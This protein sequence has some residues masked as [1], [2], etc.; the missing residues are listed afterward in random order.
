MEQ[1]SRGN[2]DGPPL[3]ALLDANVLYSKVLSDYFVHAQFGRLIAV[4]W[5]SAILEEMIRN[6]KDKASKQFSD[7]EELRPRLDAA[8]GLRN[9]IRREYPRAIVEPGP[10]HFVPFAHLSVPDPDDRHVVAAAVAARA[11]YLCT[12]NTPDFPDPVMDHLGIQRVTPDQLLHGLA[13]DKPVEMLRAHQRTIAWT[14]G[15]THRKTLDT[16]RRAQAPNT[17]DRIEK[18]LTGLGDLD[19][20]DD[21]AE[22]YASALAERDRA[23]SGLLPPST[24]RPDPREMGARPTTGFWDRQR[25][26]QQ[27][28][29][30]AYR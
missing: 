26:N 15:A 28:G 1:T 2:P 8:E 13:A 3:I 27:R 24:K 7:P 9:Y 22:V 30:G 4:K 16:L 21:L 10:E 14:P 19:S 20:R 17:A 18:L 23:R 11:N 6:K 29:I 25:L 5:S 12:N